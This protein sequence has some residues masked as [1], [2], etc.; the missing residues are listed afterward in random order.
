MALASFFGFP[1]CVAFSAT[2]WGIELL[3]LTEIHENV[4]ARL[5]DGVAV[6]ICEVLEKACGDLFRVGGFCVL[7]G[8]GRRGAWTKGSGRNI[9]GKGCDFDS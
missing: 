9:H 1:K 5:P 4:R 3:G 6:T 2:V 7:G 8:G